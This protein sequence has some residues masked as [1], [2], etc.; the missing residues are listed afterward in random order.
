MERSNDEAVDNDFRCKVAIAFSIVS[1][2]RYACIIA[3]VFLFTWYNTST[4]DR[5]IGVHC[6]SA[7]DYR[8]VFVAPIVKAIS[9]YYYFCRVYSCSFAL[10][11]KHNFM[12]FENL[13]IDLTNGWLREIN[14]SLFF[15]LATESRAESLHKIFL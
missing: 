15:F 8:A 6:E 12:H 11:V 5:V 4:F 14:L 2:I 13:T 9:T 10:V 7:L 3:Q 1:H